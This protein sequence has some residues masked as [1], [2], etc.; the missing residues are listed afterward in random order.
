[1]AVIH[2]ACSCGSNITVLTEQDQTIE[3]MAEIQAV[4]TTDFKSGITNY[5]L[6]RCEQ[7]SLPI[8]EALNLTLTRS[9]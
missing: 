5:A 1:M 7:C 3:S 4:T 2:S 9:K 8:E 6:L